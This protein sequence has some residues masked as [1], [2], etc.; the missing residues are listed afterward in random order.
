MGQRE[1]EEKLTAA[2][3]SRARDRCMELLQYV[4]K[5]K[6]REPRAVASIGK[7]LLT[8]HSWVLGDECKYAETPEE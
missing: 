7:L 6:L 3:S 5:E 2:K 1:F 4:R 8:K